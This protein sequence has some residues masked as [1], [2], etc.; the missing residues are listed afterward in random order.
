MNRIARPAW[1]AAAAALAIMGLASCAALLVGDNAQ[2]SSTA[3]KLGKD[4]GNTALHNAAQH[5]VDPVPPNV[6]AGAPALDGARAAA[7]YRR[8]RTGTVIAPEAVETTNF[9]T[10]R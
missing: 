1:R 10:D 8:Y 9:G 4:F 2:E 3:G 7:A 6:M 5:I